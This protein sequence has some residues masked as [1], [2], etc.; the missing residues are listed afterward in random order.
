MTRWLPLVLLFVSPFSSPSPSRAQYI[1]LDANGDKACTSADNFWGSNVP[2]DVYLDT[3][4]DRYGQP[5]TCPTGEPLTLGSYELVFQY[6]THYGTGAYGT[7]TNA[8]AEFGTDFGRVESGSYLR[9][10][11]GAGSL[12]AGLYKL[13][14]LVFTSTG[15]C[16]FFGVVA[17]MPGTVYGTQF[18][19][20]CPGADQDNTLRLGV[21][22]WDV[23]GA[24][25]LCD[26]VQKTT[27]GV[28]KNRYR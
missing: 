12:P 14:T 1:F 6:S 22:F 25:A 16:T 10:A 24:Y 19:S 17:S 18:G 2:V 8:I 9:V 21:D 20:A 4:H 13:G 27:W 28:I 15:D 3:S 26:D 23:C 5:V 7:W 11:Y